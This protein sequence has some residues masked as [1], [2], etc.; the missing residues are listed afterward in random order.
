MDS[1]STLAIIIIGIGL[2]LLFLPLV[3]L[4]SRSRKP[5]QLGSIILGLLAAIVIFAAGIP[6][7]GFTFLLSLP[8][9]AVLWLAS[10]FC[11]WAAWSDAAHERRAREMTL[12]LL[13]NERR[14]LGEMKDYI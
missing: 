10:L 6:G 12:R 3:V 8:A 13:I 14:G 7:S 11:A 4:S 5:L 9:V 1:F 2:F